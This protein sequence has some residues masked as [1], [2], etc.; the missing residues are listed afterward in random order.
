VRRSG[1]ALTAEGHDSLFRTSGSSER[2][3]CGRALPVVGTQVVVRVNL[4]DLPA[5]LF[6]QARQSASWRSTPARRPCGSTDPDVDAG[7]GGGRVRELA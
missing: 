5:L 1:G 7:V 6:G 4:C 2:R 3:Q